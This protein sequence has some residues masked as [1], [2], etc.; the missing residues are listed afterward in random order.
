MQDDDT[1]RQVRQVLW[2]T[3]V[4]NLFVAAGKLTVGLLTGTL[5][6]VADGFHSALDAS[7][8]VIGLAGNA[9]AARPPDDD[10]PYGHRRFE[11]IAAMMVGALLL[12]TAWEIAGQ[13]LERLQGGAEPQVTPLNFVVMLVTIAIN[14]VVSRYERREGQR[15][16]SE[17]LK[18]DAANTGA[19]VF[20]SLSVLV[21]LAAVAV[22]WAWADIAAA[23]VIVVLIGRA[24]WDVLWQTGRILVDTAPLS[25]DAI[26]AVIAD[27][28]GVIEVDRV[29]SRGPV[30]AANLDVD[31]RVASSLTTEHAQ[32]IRNTIESRLREA[33][34]GI[35]EVEVHYAP[36]YAM[37][38]DYRLVA[39][40]EA[41]AMGL[42]IHEVVLFDTPDGPVLEMHVEVPPEQMLVEAHHQV[43]SLECRIK[44]ALPV[45][46]RVIT[47]IEP[48]HRGTIPMAQ[49]ERARELRSRALKLASTLYPD[50]DWHEVYIRPE[51][52]GY[53]LSMHG[54][55]D[56][57]M[58]VEEAHV[59]AE[60]TE[61][62]LRSELPLLQRVTIHT[63]PATTP[64]E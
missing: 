59:L 45:L 19:D 13:A 44:N 8:N 9:I 1:R 62:H 10:H 49:S 32:S 12:L 43:T 5:A 30:D 63:E 11:T 46:S 64:A 18:A 31:V 51:A 16:K 2:V 24:A 42:A 20:V 60:R 7:S 52:H 27:V 34:E 55:L 26:E 21:S 48:A 37:P 3:L 23:L 22:G 41:D 6:M 14:I 54:G 39:R 40:A 29:R 25:P 4:A 28:P 61:T 15:L 57:D 35:A 58:T 50:V 53:A 38:P 36:Y 17:L 56:Q 47:H 33:F